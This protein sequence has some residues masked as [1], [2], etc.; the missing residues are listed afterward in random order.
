MNP[1]EPDQNNLPDGT[2]HSGLDARLQARL[3]DAIGQ[4]VIVTDPQG[5]IT[6]CNCVCETQRP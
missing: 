1:L 5:K 3:L 6:Y 4:A 2:V